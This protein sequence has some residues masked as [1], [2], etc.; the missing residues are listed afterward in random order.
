MSGAV[1]DPRLHA[2]RAAPKRAFQFSWSD[3][4]FRNLFWQV[5][6]VGAVVA[7]VWYLVSNTN[8]NLAQR[9]IATRFAFLGQ[10]A[11]IPIGESMIDVDARSHSA[12]SCGERYSD[13]LGVMF[14]ARRS[15]PMR[16]ASRVSVLQSRACS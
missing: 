16:C 8:R 2:T 12:T 4:R 11:S 14:L 13:K 3:P 5:V 7:T 15:M 9:H 6:I 10:V 1:L